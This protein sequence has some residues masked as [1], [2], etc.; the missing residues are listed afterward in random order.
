MLWHCHFIVTTK[1]IQY[2][3]YCFYRIVYNIVLLFFGSSGT[4]LK[5][6]TT[7]YSYSTGILLFFTSLSICYSLKLCVIMAETQESDIPHV[8]VAGWMYLLR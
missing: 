1:S 7:I 5:R 4:I 6:Y 8:G 3:Q 2:L